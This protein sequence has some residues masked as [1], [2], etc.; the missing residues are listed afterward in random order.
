MSHSTYTLYHYWRSSASWRVRLALAWKNLNYEPKHVGLLNGESDAPDYLAKNPAGAVP[1]LELTNG[2]HTGTLLTESLAIIRYLEEVH[3]EAPTLF[4]GNVLDHARIWALAE[5]INSGTQPIS[6][7]PVMHYHSSDPEEQKRWNKHWMTEG[8]A[9][10]EKLSSPYPGP[11]A[12]GNHF[13]LADVCLIPQAYSAE[14][15]HVD[16]SQFPKIK[17]ALKASANLGA[18]LKSHPD[19]FKPADFKP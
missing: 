4:P 6:N 8:L 1:V 14:R 7:L 13:S 5:T 17:S 10:F 3:P 2:S 16:L 11:F 9:V 19:H 12:Y 15:Y 18:V